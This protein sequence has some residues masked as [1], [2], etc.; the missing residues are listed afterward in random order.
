MCHDEAFTAALWL[1]LCSCDPPEWATA[2]VSNN[3][4]TFHNYI[5]D[6]LLQRITSRSGTVTISVG[7]NVQKCIYFFCSMLLSSFTFCRVVVHFYR[8]DHLL[9]QTCILPQHDV[10]NVAFR[11]LATTLHLNIY[12]YVVMYSLISLRV[13]ILLLM[14]VSQLQRILQR[15]IKGK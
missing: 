5:K 7:L 8:G 3:Y 1:V 12:I 6:T 9:S 15:G 4:R 13:Q 10:G 14:N 2:V 11:G